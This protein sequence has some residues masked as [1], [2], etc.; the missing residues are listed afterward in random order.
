MT[1]QVLLVDDG[2]QYAPLVQ[3]ELQQAF[4]FDVTFAPDPTVARP[5]LQGQHFDVVVVDVL[6]QHLTDAYDER[7]LAGEVSLTRDKEFHIS[8]LAVHPL[9]AKEG[10]GI[11]IWTGGEDNRGLHLLF[12]YQTFGIR[13]YCSKN[14]STIHPL[15]EAIEAAARGVPRRDPLLDVYLPPSDLGPVTELLFGKELWRGVWRALALGAR[16]HDE[17]GKTIGYSAKYVR[18]R[19]SE[20]IDALRELNP[21]LAK[22]GDPLDVLTS[23]A[24][25]HWEFLLDD[26]VMRLFPPPGFRPTE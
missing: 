5:L 9:V 13:S 16:G 7:R 25:R 18:N 1:L 23:Y 12:A 15:A 6:Y 26:T 24:D 20:M 3:R 8:G 22:K 14:A 21:G 17:I 4:G 2:R 10:T 11:V 19:V